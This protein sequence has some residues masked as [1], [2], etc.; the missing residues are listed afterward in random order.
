MKTCNN[1]TDEKAI[2]H[3]LLIFMMISFGLNTGTQEIYHTQQFS[4]IYKGSNVVRMTRMSNIQE[5][6]CEIQTVLMSYLCCPVLFS[7]AKP[8]Q[9]S[10]LHLSVAHPNLLGLT[11]HNWV[12][13]EVL[14]QFHINSSMYFSHTQ[15]SCSVRVATQDKPQLSCASSSPSRHA[16]HLIFHDREIM[17]H[18]STHHWKVG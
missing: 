11:N 8:P 6:I 9:H 17:K 14:A 15:A 18:L 2:H 1:Y 10:C 13:Q 3:F 7:W 12:L 5:H 4:S 16:K